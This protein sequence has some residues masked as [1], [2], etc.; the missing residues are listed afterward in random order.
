MRAL[1]FGLCVLALAA[2]SLVTAQVPAQNVANVAT[3][4]PYRINPGDQLDIS[5]W[6]EERL[7][8]SLV[9]LPDGTIT[10]PLV[11]KI[12]VA[13]RLPSEVEMA[14]SE[15][16]RNQYRGQVPD[17][18]VSVQSS[19][20]LQFS[21]LGKVRS[22]GAFTVGRYINL[23]EAL[24]LAGGPSEFAQLGNIL[25]IRK[26]GDGLRTFRV[27]LSDVLQGRPSR[28]DL[29]DGILQIQAGDTIIVP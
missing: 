15:G 10:F 4:A 1:K 12:A 23:L 2:S 13:N 21:I 6:G 24:S 27:R 18:T 29:A 26:Q 19:A 5:V 7:Q 8:K 25:V 3:P 22:P 9:V 11:G 16:L 20:G 14:V 28:A 17:V